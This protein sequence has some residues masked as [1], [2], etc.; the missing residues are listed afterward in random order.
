M[1]SDIF[2]DNI[3]T[4]RRCA[5]SAVYAVVLCLSV[6]LSMFYQNA[7]TYMIKEETPYDSLDNVV[8]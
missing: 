3:F 2:S 8:F 7:K 5:A 6:C 1:Q 4:A